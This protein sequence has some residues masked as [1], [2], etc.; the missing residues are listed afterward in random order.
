MKILR[1]DGHRLPDYD[2]ATSGYFK[3]SRLAKICTLFAKDNIP[4]CKADAYCG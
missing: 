4:A 3:I 1:R 2:K